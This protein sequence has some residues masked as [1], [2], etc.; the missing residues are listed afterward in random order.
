[1][2]EQTVKQL[3]K[4]G[5]ATQKKDQLTEIAKLK[6][7]QESEVSLL[8][9]I[10]LLIKRLLRRENSHSKPVVYFFINIKD[11]ILIK[12]LVPPKS[13]Q[14]ESQQTVYLAVTNSS[15]TKFHL[16]ILNVTNVCKI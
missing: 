11:E 12:M 10:S 14:K 4:D 5:L 13:T 6:L 15:S 8:L 16:I 2:D 3:I 9:P 1:M 7:Q